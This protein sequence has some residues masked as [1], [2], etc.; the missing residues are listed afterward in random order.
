MSSVFLPSP[1]FHSQFVPRN[2][3]S[4]CVFCSF[5]F[6]I[7]TISRAQQLVREWNRLRPPHP[8]PTEFHVFYIAM[9]KTLFRLDD[10]ETDMLASLLR[11]L[12]GNGCRHLGL[13]ILVL[14]KWGCFVVS[15]LVLLTEIY[16]KKMCLKKKYVLLCAVLWLMFSH[17][18]ISDEI[19][20]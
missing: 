7:L 14:F 8:P 17:V 18:L 2:A 19:I 20:K 4:I 6:N 15:V 3:R 10:L 5:Y 13:N 12:V 9:P 1:F 16:V 11:C